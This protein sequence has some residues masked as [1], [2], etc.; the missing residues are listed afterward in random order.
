MI[1]WVKRLKKEESGASMVLVVLSMV[2]VLGFASLAVDLGNAYKTK[3]EMQNACDLSALAAAALLPE[4]NATKQEAKKYAELNG[5][6][7]KDVT[8]S[9]IDGG[10]KVEVKI[11]QDVETYFAGVIGFNEVPVSCKA[12]AAAGEVKAKDYAIFSGTE[13]FFG[14][15]GNVLIP[16]GDIHANG[17]GDIT[18]TLNIE[19]GVIEVP[20]FNNKS[21]DGNYETYVD[22]DNYVEMPDYSE[23][24]SR[25]LR[26]VDEEGYTV[27][28]GYFP[29][30]DFYKSH[31]HDGVLTI[32]YGEKVY[33]KS[34]LDI[35]PGAGV[36]SI[37][38]QGTLKVDG[39][40]IQVPLTVEGNIIIGGDPGFD[41]KV[42]IKGN[43]IVE[44]TLGFRSETEISGTVVAGGNI[45]FSE[46]SA[47]VL[48]E[49]VVVCDS[50]EI[51]FAG[52]TVTDKY[53]NGGYSVFWGRGSG[54]H[55]NVNYGSNVNIR[56]LF[57][58]PTGEILM[59]GGTL[60]VKGSLTGY[61]IGTND[62]DLTVELPKNDPKWEFGGLPDPQK[63]RA[64][65]KLVE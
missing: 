31:I 7:K 42:V 13:A 40:G 24:I 56:A 10:E 61:Q 45:V 26:V 23:I 11:A 62:G 38:V 37:V 58:A 30:S 35:S 20:E 28:T 27:I 8:V 4:E 47:V 3:V 51:N 21:A 29:N 12:V 59:N 15:H 60:N 22:P 44:R 17:A 18:G 65:A 16:D 14:L 5:F 64:P 9:I 32:G 63:K 55:I 39:L 36:D 41:S 19:N 49:A 53:T 34:Y 6:D 46:K 2:L 50:G 54:T 52:A 33:V 57:Y 1:G 25:K 43:M 48:D